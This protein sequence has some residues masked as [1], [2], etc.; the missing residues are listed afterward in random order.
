MHFSDPMHRSGRSVVDNGLLVKL[1][2]V[3]QPAGAI[4]RCFGTLRMPRD[5][6]AP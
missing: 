6:L 5:P 4:G 2:A 3:A 1:M